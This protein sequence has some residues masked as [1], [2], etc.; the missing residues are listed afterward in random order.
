MRS[1]KKATCKVW[2]SACLLALAGCASTGNALPDLRSY[3]KS[4]QQQ[5]KAELPTVRECCPATNRFIKDSVRTRQ[6]IR[7]GH[8]LQ[9]RGGMRLFKRSD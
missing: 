8:E 9:K 7:R 3:D 1:W 2:A 4:F 5:L 6:Q